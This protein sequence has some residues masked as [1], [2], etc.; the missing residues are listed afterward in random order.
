[1]NAGGLAKARSF[2][3]AR[4]APPLDGRLVERALP[5]AR[6]RAFAEAMALFLV[7]F[8]IDDLRVLRLP[9]FLVGIAAAVLALGLGGVLHARGY[10]RRLAG[11]DDP[12]IERALA[13][14]KS[15][16]RLLAVLALA[17][18]ALWLALTAGGFDLWP[19]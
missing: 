15:T 3:A 18:L 14:A 10:A 13:R 17:A 4:R 5:A 9:G 8:A 19:A 7:G 11:R 16:H 2:L 6:A 12:A 1:M